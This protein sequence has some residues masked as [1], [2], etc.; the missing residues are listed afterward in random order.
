MTTTDTEIVEHRIKIMQAFL[1]NMKIQHQFKT[2]NAYGQWYD[3]TGPKSSIPNFELYEYRIKPEL[4]QYRVGLFK[5][6]DFYYSLLFEDEVNA[7]NTV[8]F[9]P[10]FVRWLTDWIE[11]ET[12]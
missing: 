4:N 1:D 12:P 9:S 8:E 2:G 5:Q 6:N 11:Y 10:Q 7:Y 3:G